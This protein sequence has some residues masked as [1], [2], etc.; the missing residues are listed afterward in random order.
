MV[1]CDNVWLLRRDQIF[2]DVAEKTEM[3]HVSIATS[4]SDGSF[5]SA[6]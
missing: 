6:L 5:K 4:Y 3:V 1:A 2:F